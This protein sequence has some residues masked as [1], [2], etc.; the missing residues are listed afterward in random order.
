MNGAKDPTNDASVAANG[1]MLAN[2][3]LDNSANPGRDKP[4]MVPSV[5]ETPEWVTVHNMESTVVA[6]GFD[7]AQA[8][9]NGIQAAC[10]QFGIH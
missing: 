9:C 10:K 2:G 7:S 4:H 6:D 8:I 5:L 1:L 3:S